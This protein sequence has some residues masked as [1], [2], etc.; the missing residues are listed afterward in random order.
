[1][2]SCEDLKKNHK[3]YFFSCTCESGFSIRCAE[4][5][6]TEAPEGNERTARPIPAKGDRACFL[7]CAGAG[8]T[9]TTTE[10]VDTLWSKPVCNATRY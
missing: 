7:H 1:M 5:G 9:Q 3:N 2:P 6:E 4:V 8:P 10:A